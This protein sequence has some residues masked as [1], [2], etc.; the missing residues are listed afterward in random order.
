MS[1][2]GKKFAKVYHSLYSS[3]EQLQMAL[4]TY[5]FIKLGLNNEKSIYTLPLQSLHL[6]SFHL[7]SLLLQ[8][9]RLVSLVSLV[10]KT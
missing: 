1:Q 4:L 7:L 9:L 5:I 8:T 3:T 6:L 2:F 10:T